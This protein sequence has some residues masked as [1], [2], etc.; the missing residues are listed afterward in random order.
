MENEDQEEP[1]DRGDGET[2]L[3]LGKRAEGCWRGLPRLL[4]AVA[5]SAGSHGCS[6]PGAALRLPSGPADMESLGRDAASAPPLETGDAGEEEIAFL[7]LV[8][9]HGTT[10]PGL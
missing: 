9:R 4:G 8:H 5:P 7:F 2:R 6:D 3:P 1:G 10:R